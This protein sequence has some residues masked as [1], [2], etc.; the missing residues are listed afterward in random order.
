MLLQK[1]CGLVSMIT[2]VENISGFSSDN[3]HQKN[4]TRYRIN[5]GSY[6][7]WKEEEFDENYERKK[8]LDKLNEV[9]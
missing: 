5:R 9:V 2:E 8:K 6:Y 1:N 7:W 3:E 4:F